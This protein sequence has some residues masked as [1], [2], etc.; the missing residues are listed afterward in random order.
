MLLLEKIKVKLN[1]KV[2]YVLLTTGAFIL[3]LE[4]LWY[5]VATKYRNQETANKKQIELIFDKIKTFLDNICV[6]SAHIE[7]K[8]DHVYPNIKLQRQSFFLTID[9]AKYRENEAKYCYYRQT[10]PWMVVY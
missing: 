6:I 2:A 10:P 3:F 4:H 1:E 9:F 5:I 7:H 8:H